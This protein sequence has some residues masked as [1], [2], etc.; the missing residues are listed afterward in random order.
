MPSVLLQREEKEEKL[1][2]FCRKIVFSSDGCPPSLTPVSKD[3]V[4]C[5]I[6]SVPSFDCRFRYYYIRVLLKCSIQRLFLA[7][8][9]NIN[10]P[11]CIASLPQEYKNVMF[12]VPQNSSRVASVRSS[13]IGFSNPGY[14]R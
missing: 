10:D 13:W 12:S 2:K 4:A 3:T 11:S 6:L 9:S 5:S 8:F 7:R 1:Y 14:R